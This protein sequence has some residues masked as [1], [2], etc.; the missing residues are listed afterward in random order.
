MQTCCFYYRFQF[1]LYRQELWWFQYSV[2]HSSHQNGNDNV[3][4]VTTVHATL[5]FC[6]GRRCVLMRHLWKANH[7]WETESLHYWGLAEYSA[8]WLLASQVLHFHLCHF[9]C[10]PNTGAIGHVPILICPLALYLCAVIV[11]RKHRWPQALVWIIF[12]RQHS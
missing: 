1:V 5:Y 8:D 3:Q 2:S 6:Q 4:Y 12:L 10:T 9:L 7:G 11:A